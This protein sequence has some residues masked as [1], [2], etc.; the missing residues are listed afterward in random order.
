VPKT[1]DTA[2]DVG[3]RG[4]TAGKAASLPPE[5]I[6]LDAKMI[7]FLGNLPSPAQIFLQAPFTGQRFKLDYDY[8]YLRTE[9]P[10]SIRLL[11]AC[12][13]FNRHFLTF[14]SGTRLSRYCQP[15]E[16]GNWRLICRQATVAKRSRGE[17][18]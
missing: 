13:L 12:Y 11:A 3:W 5:D 10:S 4:T 18:P 7:A 9:L 2:G 8:Y 1:A 16:H 6:D 14:A 17:E 15:E